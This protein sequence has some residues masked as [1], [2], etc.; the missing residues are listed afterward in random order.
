L[1]PLFEAHNVDIVLAGHDHLYER[2]Y[3]IKNDSLSTV[4]DGG[5]IYVTNGEGG[6]MA[7]DYDFINP[8]PDWSAARSKHDNPG[9]P[10]PIYLA[11]YTHIYIDNGI[12]S[13]ITIND[14]GNAI[15]P[16]GSTDPI[17]I[18]DRS[19]EPGALCSTNLSNISGVVYEDT[20][21]DKAFSAGDTPLVGVQIDLSNGQNTTTD[22]SGIYTFTNLAPGVYTITE[23]DPPGYVSVADKHGV[24]DNLITITLASGDSVD[25]LDF[26]DGV[27]GSSQPFIYLPIILKKN[28]TN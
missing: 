11:S 6:G 1:I 12:M 8:A 18:I 28:S 25:E 24:N 19:N 16:V 15:D 9:D 5:V 21:G 20:D 2:T 27:S 17:V 23:N 13:L 22:S 14:Q 26:L 7:A 4:M 10:D 3:P